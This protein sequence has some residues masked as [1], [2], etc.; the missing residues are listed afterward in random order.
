MNHLWYII[1]SHSNSPE[2]VAEGTQILERFFKLKM[3]SMIKPTNYLESITAYVQWQNETVRR[4]V[5]K[6]KEKQRDD[7]LLE[8][9]RLWNWN[10]R[11]NET[12]FFG[13]AARPLHLKKVTEF[14]SQISVYYDALWPLY[15]ENRNSLVQA[16]TTLLHQESRLYWPNYDIFPCTMSNTIIDKCLQY[17]FFNDRQNTWFINSSPLD[18]I[19]F[20]SAART[21][22]AEKFI[23][24]D[25]RSPE[26]HNTGWIL[27][28]LRR[29][30]RTIN[31]QENNR[32]KPVII[33]L[34][35]SKNRFGHRIDVDLIHSDL[36][37]DFSNVVTIVDACQDGQSFREVDI[38]LYT[39]R[40]AATGA[41]GLVNQLFLSKH[42]ALQ[43][44][45]T[46][47]TTF[48]IGILAQ[49]YIN[50]NMAN[51]GLAHGVEDLVNSAWWPFWQCPIEHQL[52]SVFNFSDS[53]Q[54]VIECSRHPIRY[55]FTKDLTG[56]ILM[57]TTNRDGEVILPKLWALLKK[58]GHSLDC[59][60][61]DNPYLK[62]PNALK[63]RE[64]Q[65]LIEEKFVEK[66]RETQLLLSDYLV[67]PLV[68]NWVSSPD[69]LL[70]DELTEHFQVCYDYH[71]CLRISIGRC[72]YPGKLKRLVEHIDRIFRNNELDLPD[73]AL[74][75]YPSQWTS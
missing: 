32:K 40:F 43:R 6:F 75:K 28:N 27:N 37:K 31:S 39:K 11:E 42:A 70:D 38:I 22:F 2:A 60:V 33:I 12:M 17:F 69:D 58:Q 46:A 24:S 63:S 48:P 3:R 51:T 10:L 72:A 49:I 13:G 73:D 41:V 56:T 8:I 74:G 9:E 36:T 66:L 7:R 34:L 59:F 62:N 53:Y 20:V 45:L 64:I 1:E 26:Q 29:H 35:T 55:S 68:P 19:P 14:A 16:L 30:C 54:S 67:W 5:E 52:N 61:I 15:K 4:F 18:Y 57:L 65:H 21:I 47:I 23:G 50:V 44:K 71:C 25:M